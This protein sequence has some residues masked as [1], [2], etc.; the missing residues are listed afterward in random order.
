MSEYTE[1]FNL[2]LY[3]DTDKPNLR[4]QYNVAI[5]KIDSQ[6]KVQSDNN[7]VAI[8]A[9]NQAKD[10]AESIVATVNTNTTSINKNTNDIANNT[11]AITICFFKV[12]F[13]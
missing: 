13:L 7:T 5:R 2:D 9:A 1:N 8:E 11:T 4:D 3:T 12:R 6:L 10:K